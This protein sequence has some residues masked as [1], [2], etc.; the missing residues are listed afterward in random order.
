MYTLP[1]HLQHCVKLC[2]LTYT[3]EHS[4]YIQ[5]SSQLVTDPAGILQAYAAFRFDELRL[6]H[7]DE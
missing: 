2:V 1:R 3:A 4:L 6:Q 5:V 7:G